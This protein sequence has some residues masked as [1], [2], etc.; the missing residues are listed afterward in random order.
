MN[1]TN[2]TLGW[3]TME[4]V[5]QWIDRRSCAR[6]LRGDPALETVAAV[7]EQLALLGTF[8]RIHDDGSNPNMPKGPATV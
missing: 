3:W 4:A 7:N 1:S 6:L 8:E 2:E 5:A